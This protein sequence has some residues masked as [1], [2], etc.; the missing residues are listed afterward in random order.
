MTAGDPLPARRERLALALG[1]TEE[2]LLVGA[3]EPIPIPGGADQCYRFLA[4]PEYVYLTD[5]EIPGAV[6][7]FDPGA[8]WT[9]FAPEVTEQQRIWEGRS[10]L[11]PG[12]EPLAGLSG[13]LARRRERPV[14]NLGAA[15][16]G[17]RP[18]AGRTAEL[19]ARFSHARRAKDAVE[20]DR[21]R[22]AVVASVDGYRRA[23]DLVRPG[24]S[25]RGIAIELEAAFFRAGA[26]RTCYDTIVGSGPNAAVFHFTPGGRR[27][28]P[29][30]VVLIDAGAE[31]RRYGCDITRV[32]P[33]D[34]SWSGPA[35]EVRAVVAR[36]LDRAVERCG[37]GVEMLDVH[38][39]ACVD[40]T[41]GL[42]AMGLLRGAVESLVERGA[43]ALFF[44]HGIGHLV[45]LGVR[46]AGGGLP[47]RA[48]R[49]APGLK[50]LRADLPL[51]PGYVTTIE[52]G[53]YFVPALLRDPGRRRA[54]GDAVD[55][56]RAESLLP[57]GGIRL[58]ENVLV[59]PTG[60][61]N[62]TGAIPR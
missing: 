34:G 5:R 59:T 44:P 22:R 10:E 24:A 55:W 39:G 37:P 26:D 45:G 21:I 30:E 60:R 42:V 41:E 20:L 8:G 16:P 17:I 14:V 33:A 19:R 2:L 9:H 4:H 28:R 36:A 38:L 32:Y 15:L 1:L 31:I 62:L 29:G 53:I 50:A 56:E 13:W 11:P 52:P 12:A 35:S 43:H 6:V 18:D 61:E 57:L 51:L 40:L 27:V 49:P 54:L 3:G 58:E 25:E 23:P 48:P 7:A 46:D 47:G